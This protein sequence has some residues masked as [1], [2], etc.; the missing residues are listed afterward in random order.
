LRGQFDLVQQAF[1]QVEAGQDEEARAALQNIGLQSPF[2]EWKLL[3]RGLIAYYQNDD[4]RAVENWQRLNAELLPARL[5]AP[6]RFAIDK[7]FRAAQPPATQTA[8]QQQADR[9]QG[10]GLVPA[11]R[12]IQKAIVNEHQLPQA[13][14]QAENVLPTL[15]HDAPHQ[16]P[17]LA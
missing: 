17:R 9:L 10:S 8:L 2:L 12:G 15:R 6:L 14:R 5:A 16:V 4:A 1:K 11:L 7:D 3:L 13:F